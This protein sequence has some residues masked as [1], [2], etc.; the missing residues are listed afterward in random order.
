MRTTPTTPTI[1]EGATPT[2][3]QQPDGQFVVPKATEMAMAGLMSDYEAT[4]WFERLAEGLPPGPLEWRL[5]AGEE[6][7]QRI[8]LPVADDDRQAVV[9]D[10]WR[11]LAVRHRDIGLRYLRA[12][13]SAART[14]VLVAALADAPAEAL[15]ALGRL[16]GG[17]RGADTTLGE[18]V[19]GR[20]DLMAP[21]RSVAVVLRV[22]HAALT[23]GDEGVETAVAAL[24]RG[25]AARV[26]LNDRHR[27][28]ASVALWS[29]ANGSPDESALQKAA[30]ALAGC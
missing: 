1:A 25:G 3:F 27:A 18:V 15:G 13:D 9:R 12:P 20:T 21:E 24:S 30:V 29:R 17:V 22:A 10:A 6:P 23:G 8:D 5:R 14:E 28:R 11:V 19:A 7:D 26:G 4:R 2:Q 16:A